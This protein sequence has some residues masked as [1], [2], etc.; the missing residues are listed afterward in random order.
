MISKQDLKDYEF[1]DIDQYYDYVID[2][3]INGQ[4]SQVRRLIKNLSKKQ[5][6]DFICYLE[7]ID[8]SLLKEIKHVRRTL[9]E[10]L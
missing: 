5:K 1:K 8:S 4:F 3:E 7:R 9:T 10:L 6:L 2:S